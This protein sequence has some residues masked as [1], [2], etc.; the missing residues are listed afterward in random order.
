[1]AV[2]TVNMNP[3]H[4]VITN[5]GIYRD[6]EITGSHKNSM[7]SMAKSVTSLF[8]NDPI[9]SS[10]L[11]CQTFTDL[12]PR[13]LIHTYQDLRINKV[14]SY[15]ELPLNTRKC[16]INENDFRE[17]YYHTRRNS[18]AS[19]N[20]FSSIYKSSRSRSPSVTSSN[21]FFSPFAQ[22]SSF[23]IRKPKKLK[24]ALARMSMSKKSQSKEKKIPRT[25]L[26]ASEKMRGKAV[27]KK[28]T[29]NKKFSKLN[30]ELNSSKAKSSTCSVGAPSL[31]NFSMAHVNN[32]NVYN[33][34]KLKCLIAGDAQV[35]KTALMF[36]FL[37]RA[38]QYEYQPT[39]VDDYEGKFNST[40]LGY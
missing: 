3:I 23:R 36:L 37:N 1:M 19:T 4:N 2:G 5:P 38:F 20:S 28:K 12:S 31:S 6:I 34:K 16:F 9:L 8:I 13:P 25:K 33:D 7:N 14:G 26:N 11:N 39:I 30:E 27:T 22:D 24:L 10:S 18:T 17:S 29:K 15:I 40:Y 35:G 21:S 32:S